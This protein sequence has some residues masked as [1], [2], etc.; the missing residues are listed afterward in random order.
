VAIQNSSYPE[1]RRLRLASYDY[2]EDG[3]YFVT[4]VTEGRAALFGRIDDSEMRLSQLGAIVEACWFDLP[5]H[6]NHLVVDEFIV[7]PN[8]IHGVVWLRRAG[9]PGF[10]PAPT[11]DGSRPHVLPEI[12]RAFKTFSARRINALRGTSGVAVWQRSYYERVIRD[13]RELNAIREYIRSN[14]VNWQLD[15]EHL[16]IR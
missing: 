13:N 10:K 8:H 14:P 7:M 1:R 6:Y 5:K 15:R 12:V 9:R 16:P 2:S 3:A 11:N 4:A